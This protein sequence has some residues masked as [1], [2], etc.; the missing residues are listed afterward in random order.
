MIR[1]LVEGLGEDM[2][3]RTGCSRTQITVAAS[4]GRDFIPTTVTVLFATRKNVINLPEMVRSEEA[5]TQ[6]S[7]CVTVALPPMRSL[8]FRK[9]RSRH[10]DVGKV[11]NAWHGFKNNSDTCVNDTVSPHHNEHPCSRQQLLGNQ[12]PCA[13]ARMVRTIIGKTFRLGFPLRQCTFRDACVPRRA[14]RCQRFALVNDS[15]S[16]LACKMV[17]FVEIHNCFFPEKIDVVSTNFWT[18]FV[19]FAACDG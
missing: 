18:S 2:L 9:Q 5:S 1:C 4:S 13:L 17:I 8:E 16:V 12:L 14:A 7:V 15:Y 19:K 3:P 11:E 10:E 6:L